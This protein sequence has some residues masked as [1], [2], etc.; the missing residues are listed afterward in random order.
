MTKES[1]DT[2]KKEVGT[3]STPQFQCPILKPSNYSLWAI[4]MQIILEA[5]GLWEMI[6]PN[7]KTQADN[8]KDK[9]AMAFLY[10]ALPDVQLLQITKYK[11]AK[12][13]WDALTTRHIREER[14]HKARLQTL[15]SDF[16]M[17]HMKED[18]TIDTFTTKLTT[19]VNKAASLGHTMEYETLVRKL[20]NVVPDRYLQ[21]VASIE[22]YSDLSEMTL[23][24]AI[25]RL[26]TYEERIKYK[27]GK[28]VDN[29]E[30]LMFTRHENKGKYFR[31]R[32]RGK[33]RFSQERNHENFKG[34]R[35]DGE[36]S[37][38][39]Y[40]KN[41]FKKSN[42]DTSKLRCYKCKEIG[43]I[44]PKC[45]QKT[46]SNEQ[47]NLVEEDL[48]P[49]LL[50][51]ILED[52]EEQNVSLHEEDV[53]YKETNKDSLWYLDN[54][55]S[56]HMT[57][58]RE[59]FKEL[60]EKVSGKV[61]FG[62]G[63]YI[64]I[65]GKGS[66]LIEC[67]DE[68]QRI[69]SHV[70]YIP[71]LKSNLLSLGQFTEIGCK[72]VMEDDELQLYDMDNKIFIRVTRQRNRLYK[73]NLRIGTPVCLLANL[74]DDSW[75]WHARLGHLN[76][77]S[78]KSM[79]QKDLVHGIPTIK[80][81][82]QICDVC[83][84]GKHSRAP[85][86]KKSKARSTSPLD[87]VYGDLCGP[88]TP[89]TPS[90]KKYIFLLVDD[91][92]RYMWVYF[93]TTK[94]QAFDTFK[95]FK[96]S[97]ENELR[98][99]LKMLRTDRGGEFTSNEFMLYCK[100]NGIARQLTA[101]YS[102]QQNGVVEAVRHAIYILN[103]VPTKALEDITP[104]E[105]IKQ[106]KPNLEN[107]RV[108][109]CI[110][111]AKVPSQHLTK[112]DDRSTR[113]VYLGNEQGSKAYRLFDPTTQRIC[114]SR[115]VKFKENETWDWKDYMSEHTNDEPEWTDFRIGNLEVTDE[116]HDQ[117]T[118]PTEEDN[119]FPNNNDDDVYASPTRD[120]PTHSQ[121]PHTPSTRSSEVNSQVTPNIST[122]SYYQSDN[123]TIQTINSPSHF[124]H[125]P[126][127]GFRTLNDLYENTE[128]L[129]LAEDEPKNYKEASNDQKWIE[130]MKAE[131]DSINRN[132]TWKLTTLPKGHKA[133]GL[134]WV[135]KTKRDANGNIIKHKARL[136]AK[137]YIQEHGID[138]EEVFAPVAR[139]ETIRLLL[140]IAANNKWEVHHLD[141][142][143]A[144]LHGDL[145][146][147]VYVT[148]PE[149]FIK[150]Q[151][152]GKVYRLIKALY[153][154]RQAP[155][156]W[157]I[158]LD[159]T[160]K[161][162][163]FK[164]CALEQAIYIKTSKDSTLLI[165]VYVDDLIITG[166]PKKEID[167]FKAQMEE[168]F[169]MSDLGLLA[170]YLGIEVTQTNGDISIKQSAYASKIL[171]EAGM[172]DCNE[173]LIPMD[174]GTRLTKITE[175]T[176]VN[177]TEYRSLIGCLRYLLH[178]RPD[179]SYSVGLLSR[180]MQ[181]PREQHMK[182]IR[183]VLRY[184]K[185]TKDYGITY[186]HN[187]GNKIHGYSDSSYGVNTTEGKGTTGIIFYYGCRNS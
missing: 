150:K 155:R 89:P 121:T 120:S 105:A 169:E 80:H 3:T 125:T 149:G 167:K 97:I 91:Y 126:I 178:T 176:M 2:S 180:S 62:D 7:E 123:D 38:R 146:E 18:E 44:A 128:E 21:I 184:V 117:G 73:A 160:L 50:M 58:I 102:P 78:L 112:L 36:T 22:Q 15:K 107:L 133:I 13:I 54:G 66:I 113:M 99:T 122:Q 8:K 19:L 186:K 100:E 72:V 134:K 20:L 86:P 175:G 115:D 159:N 152:Q 129:L 46:K 142:K 181:E 12:T 177:S 41:N 29:Q 141:V 59:H 118:Q 65:K 153:G 6:E 104:Y 101:P 185:G 132:N 106:R 136:V 63:S 37:H 1:G 162:L 87:L 143:S 34:E 11:T 157:N 94:D 31:G 124:D 52:E 168:K 130:A 151:D 68:K 47:S 43:H 90:G 131:L 170:Y 109:G 145:K 103:S 174:P 93:L 166:T 79:A 5:N 182:A 173:T 26:K 4:R 172:I 147:E 9:T 144:F 27:K 48:E 16:E 84:I 98:T 137:G 28:Q 64:E 171:K 148:Q 164:K 139:M 45:P 111:Y 108:F 135:F 35:K 67:D 140:A 116:R 183:Q 156:A 92:S 70:Y 55:A 51:A 154:L 33:H 88:I 77:E 69:I 14:I 25:G 10:Q 158:K 53:G 24:E 57:G 40:N 76:F 187:G 127:R 85:F 114:V 165:G 56:N 71:D 138:F 161:S 83:L 110:A 39:S 17:L 60:D 82:T 95:E 163:D 23:E 74:K 30:K 32:G 75:L 96:N 179:L 49:T 42:Y 81:T 119:E 61:R